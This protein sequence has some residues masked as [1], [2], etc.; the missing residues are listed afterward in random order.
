MKK[1]PRGLFVKLEPVSEHSFMQKDWLN[2]KISNT[3]YIINCV[4][5]CM[6]IIEDDK[7]PRGLFVKLEPVSEHSFMQKDWLNTK[8]SNTAY[9][10]LIV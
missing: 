8:I 10:L 2:T 3:A 7:P 9:I 1:P 5:K 4:S 6:G